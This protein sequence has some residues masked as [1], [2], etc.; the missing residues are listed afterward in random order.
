LAKP[1]LC[2]LS[3]TCD[4]ISVIRR[5][6][7]KRLAF[8]SALVVSSFVFG[9]ATY[10]PYKDIT[11]TELKD[12]LEKKNDLG[13]SMSAPRKSTRARLVICPEPF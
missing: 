12:R 5:I 8:W 13:Y 9:C 11:V 1:S 7:M 4:A 10:K 3:D 6:R 2:D